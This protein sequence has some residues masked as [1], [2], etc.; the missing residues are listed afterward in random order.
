MI[1]EIIGIFGFI[2][3]VLVLLLID[4]IIIFEIIQSRRKIVL[5]VVWS[6][7]IFIFP[8]FGALI[9]YLFSNRNILIED[10]VEYTYLIDQDEV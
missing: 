5:K 1:N 6:V 9:Y 3:L 8:I 4:L 7:L 2:V 10:P